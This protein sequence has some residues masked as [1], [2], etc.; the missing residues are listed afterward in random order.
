M[1]EK[2]PSERNGSIGYLGHDPE[3]FNDTIEH[4]ILMGD[5]ANA[6]QYLQ[7]V[8]LD[9]EVAEME[10]GMQTLVGN[11]GV[12]LSG[13]QAQ[14]LA[15]ARTLCHRR[16]LLILDDPFS[17]LDQKTEREIFDKL[18]QNY[19]DTAILLDF[20]QIVSLPRDGS[21]YLDGKM[22]RRPFPIMRH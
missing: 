19:P 10:Q 21:G 18:K 4:N 22:D 14:R 7:E 20:S 16:P 13:G 3:L 1:Q 6:E 17:A 15:L 9:Q 2:Q 5:S 12:R 8:C 11:G